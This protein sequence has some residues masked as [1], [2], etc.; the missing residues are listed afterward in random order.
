MGE[1]KCEKYK[2]SQKPAIK[3][4]DGQGCFIVNYAP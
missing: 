2:T 4:S 1:M 3:Q